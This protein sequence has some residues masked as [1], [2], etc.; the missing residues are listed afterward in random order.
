MF[1]QTNAVKNQ[2]KYIQNRNNLKFNEAI[3]FNE[4]ALD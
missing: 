2:I 1:S 4:Q 3:R